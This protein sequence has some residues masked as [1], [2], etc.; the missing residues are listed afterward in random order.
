MSPPPPLENSPA[1]GFMESGGLKNKI[2]DEFDGINLVAAPAVQFSLSD[3]NGTRELRNSIILLSHFT[4][5]IRQHAKFYLI[6]TIGLAH[7]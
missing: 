3:G 2:D 6:Y 5:S 4:I 1:A 7:K